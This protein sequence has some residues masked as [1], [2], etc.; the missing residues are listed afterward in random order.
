[1]Q[2]TSN[3][4]EDPFTHHH[5]LIHLIQLGNNYQLEQLLFI[6]KEIEKTSLI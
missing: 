1:M 4:F 3:S 2:G 5:T 6:K